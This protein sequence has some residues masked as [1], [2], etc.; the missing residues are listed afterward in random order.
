MACHQAAEGIK[1]IFTKSVVCLVNEY[2]R[3]CAITNCLKPTNSNT[4]VSV[5]C[6]GYFNKMTT[7]EMPQ[8]NRYKQYK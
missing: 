2:H 7:Y 6:C 5:V 4:F 3:F 8:L 1:Y